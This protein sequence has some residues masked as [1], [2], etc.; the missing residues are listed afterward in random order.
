VRYVRRLLQEQREGLT[1]TTG[2]TANCGFRRRKDEVLESAASAEGVNG[3][4]WYES[5][6]L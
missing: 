4:G 2:S 1:D 6:Y 5:S 3:G